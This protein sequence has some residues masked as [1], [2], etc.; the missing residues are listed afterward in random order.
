VLKVKDKKFGWEDDSIC[1]PQ[2]IKR[3]RMKIDQVWA[4]INSVLNSDFLAQN[5]KQFEIIDKIGSP[6]EHPERDP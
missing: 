6:G 4:L 1:S 5:L 3:S 2:R